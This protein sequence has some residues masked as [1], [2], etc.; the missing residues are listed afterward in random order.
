[1]GKNKIK[2][3]LV[4]I[5]G[6]G[7]KYVNALLDIGEQDEIMITGVVDPIPEGFDRL[8]DIKARGIE[9]FPSIEDFY[10]KKNADLAVISSPM[11]YHKSQIIHA[12]NNESHV[13]CEKPMCVTLE[14]GMQIIAQAE[15]SSKKVAIGYQWSFSEAMLSLKKDI[16]GGVFGKPKKFKTIVLWPRPYS[17]YNRNN[18]V[19]K[20]KDRNG[21]M[22]LD[23]VANNATAHY[24]HNMFFVLGRNIDSSAKPVKVQA[25][26]YK[27]NKIENFDTCAF[28]VITEDETQ[29]LFIASHAVKT[30][31]GPEFI[32]EFENA[33]IEYNSST[34]REIIA[35]FN[36]GKCISYGDPTDNEL[37]KLW[38]MI[39]AIKD[40]E[41]IPCPPK[42][43]FS[44]TICIDAAHRSCTRVI[45][46]PESMV[47]EDFIFKKDRGAYVKNLSSI[48]EDCYI[49]FRM[50]SE[51]DAVWSV[52]GLNVI[53]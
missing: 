16:I 40:N 7:S 38:H 10:S 41:K 25:E 36:N 11:Q 30:I 47:I 45:P 17:Y 53:L 44:H 8:I 9:I 15:R 3:L 52:R 24:L 13:L 2:I 22:I 43:A 29:I 46:F 18:W 23:S 37:N 1:M 5:G 21:N 19:G 34:S 6:Y 42:A 48:L 32:Y 39:K 50:P 12:L 31:K 33:K 35:F 26:L 4:G 28:K 49:K 51:T 20:I 14:D 27:A